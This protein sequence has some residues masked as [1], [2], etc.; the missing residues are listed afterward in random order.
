MLDNFFLNPRLLRIE[1]FNHL[2]PPEVAAE[3]GRID[4]VNSMLTRLYDR[5]APT[6]YKHPIQELIMAAVRRQ[7]YNILSRFKH[8][9]SNV[10][11]ILYLVCRQPDG[12]KLLQDKHTCDILLN[13]KTMSYQY[14]VNN[15]TPLMIAVKYRRVKCVEKLLQSS[16]CDKEVL[17]MSSKPMKSTVFHICAEV[18][19]K[20]ITKLLFDAVEN[21][22]KSKH[23]FVITSDIM[24]NT[25]LHICAQEDNS[26]MSDKILSSRKYLLTPHSNSEHYYDVLTTKNND[27]LT[28]FHQAVTN[29]YNDI[30]KIMIGFATEFSVKKKLIYDADQTLRCSLHMAA[31]IG[32][33]MLNCS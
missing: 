8:Q 19:N 32:K 7:G 11:S 26:H 33:F 1:T 24:G 15:F 2:S 14:E 28:A 30:V 23:V 18:K 9:A 12:Y 31:S 29:G 22:N 10:P 4:I 20:E 27:G 21:A 16:F 25:P 17:E 6:D 5:P 13:K 3:Y